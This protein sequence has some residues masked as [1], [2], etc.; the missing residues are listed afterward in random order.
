MSESLN[1]LIAGFDSFSPHESEFDNQERLQALADRWLEQPL[2]RRAESVR[3]I[4]SLF[5]RNPDADAFGSPGPLV[6]ALEKHAV[7]GG[8]ERYRADLIDS[9]KRTPSSYTVWMVNRLLNAETQSDR[10]AELLTALRNA[11]E[12]PTAVQSVRN[13]AKEFLERQD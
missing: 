9:V 10:R 3:S 8:M 4:L 11:S 12:N 7:Q 5:E 1:R 13:R 6:H 2:D